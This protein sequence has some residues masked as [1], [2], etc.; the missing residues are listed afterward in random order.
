MR[1]LQYI[2]NS[3]NVGITADYVTM[4]TSSLDKYASVTL[5]TTFAA[6]RQSATDSTPD[7]VHI[8]GGWSLLAARVLLWAEQK[9]WPVVLSLH[10]ALMP[11]QWHRGTRIPNTV[12]RYTFLEKAIR[13]ADAIHVSGEMEQHRMEQ[14]AWNPRIALVHNALITQQTTPDHMAAEMEKLY[15]K[16][17][18]SNTFRLMTDEE[19]HAENILLR[20]GLNSTVES[21]ME[22]VSTLDIAASLRQ[23][24]SPL[25][26]PLSFRKILLHAS[27][28]H[29]LDYIRLPLETSSLTLEET[30]FTLEKG[31]ECEDRFPQKL[32]KPDGFLPTDHLTARHALKTKATLDHLRQD[33]NPSD[34]EMSI[35]HLLLNIQHAMSRATLSRRHLAQLFSLLRWN[36]YDEDK[37]QRMLHR[38]HLEP[39]TA[40]L[41]QILHES[42]DLEIGFMPIEPR[43]DKNTARIRQTLKILNIQ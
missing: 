38:L 37:L 33:E 26:S 24:L 32:Q 39:F 22:G 2:P 9:G 27:D 30:P 8:H 25:T 13:E 12:R 29:I 5:T 28:E 35:C 1:V 40:S 14:L 21:N 4:L 23:D 41:L 10:G 15:Q 34:T 17:I 7:I 31:L 43:D 36:D 18:D 19:K 3:L 6:F 20:A 42:L 11:W 16:V